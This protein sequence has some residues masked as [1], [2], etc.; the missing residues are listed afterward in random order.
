M[1]S[2]LLLVILFMLCVTEG[3]MKCMMHPRFRACSNQWPLLRM[4]VR[5]CREDGLLR[6]SACS[7]T[8]FLYTPSLCGVTS[9][10]PRVCVCG[11]G[12]R[13]FDALPIVSCNILVHHRCCIRIKEHP[14]AA[15]LVLVWFCMHTCVNLPWINRIHLCISL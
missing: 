8:S 11:C 12:L 7:P 9:F 1:F 10:C 6:I 2:L 15:F 3:N 4:I 14:L 5:Q 13:I